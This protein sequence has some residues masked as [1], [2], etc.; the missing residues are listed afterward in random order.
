MT[1]SSNPNL[2]Y[3]L[4]D[5]IFILGLVLDIMQVFI[6]A[7]SCLCFTSHSLSLQ[8]R[9]AQPQNKTLCEH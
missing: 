5:G 4:F 7:R 2:I 1:K 3:T 8:E 9:V 6:N